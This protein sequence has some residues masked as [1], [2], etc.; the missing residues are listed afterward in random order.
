MSLEIN[1]HEF[2]ET[3]FGHVNIILD[4]G[5]TH[6][7]FIKTYD[8]D[9]KIINTEFNDNSY[10]FVFDNLFTHKDT[11]ET[12]YRNSIEHILSL[13]AEGQNGLIL[14]YS[15]SKHIDL[16]NDLLHKAFQYFSDLINTSDLECSVSG[17]V[18]LEASD[19]IDYQS[20]NWNT[21]FG[22][23]EHEEYHK[24]SMFIFKLTNPETELVTYL[25]IINLIPDS[26]D[27][28][29]DTLFTTNGYSSAENESEHMTNYKMLALV[30][31]YLE[32][33]VNKSIFITISPEL[34]R[35]QETLTGL[36]T[37]SSF[38]IPITSELV[39]KNDQMTERLESEVDRL[40]ENSSKFDILCE[41]LVNEDERNK[42]IINSLERQIETDN[43]IKAFEEK[44]MRKIN[45][46]EQFYKQTIRK[47]N[48]EYQNN[49]E[50]FFKQLK[51]SENTIASLEQENRVVKDENKK[52]KERSDFDSNGLK[53]NFCEKL[54]NDL[55]Q[56]NRK[57]KKELLVKG[58]IIGLNIGY[59]IEE[60][61]KEI[62]QLSKKLR[63]LKNATQI[64]Q[65]DRV[66]QSMLTITS[67]EM[68]EYVDKLSSE[69]LEKK[70]L[71][72]MELEN[73]ILELK[74]S[75]KKRMREEARRNSASMPEC[76][77]KSISS[78]NSNCLQKSTSTIGQF[79]EGEL[80]NKLNELR[81][82][83]IESEKKSMDLE[84]DFINLKL[85]INK[86]K[87]KLITL[88]ELT[89][90]FDNNKLNLSEIN[91][92]LL[93]HKTDHKLKLS[94]LSE[95]IDRLKESVP[96]IRLENLD[97]LKMNNPTKSNII[98]KYNLM[99]SCYSSLVQ[100]ILKSSYRNSQIFLKAIDVMIKRVIA[101]VDK[102]TLDTV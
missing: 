13:S 89:M 24:Y 15:N 79:E 8:T 1:Q 39:F 17:I 68:F 32:A 54:M 5:I 35:Y 28:N 82:N 45:E 94:S 63:D 69:E 65:E 25:Y 77:L 101:V 71:R 67:C 29:E 76:V 49:I 93:L 70:D 9:T 97:T 36:L 6:K 16:T 57:L 58:N 31:K 18:D 38:I 34:H 102:D 52:L 7:S 19:S 73:Q 4:S 21:K 75:V 50:Q 99:L 78:Y 59:F 12:I 85:Q 100:D 30:G 22:D 74:T 56:E 72:I 48:Q 60:Y 66:I 40:I 47:N 90:S 42:N 95:L 37:A 23:V 46:I 51:E 20:I 98:D 91:E 62:F 26:V 2:S 3:N 27:E 92:K 84:K 14:A 55:Y 61:Q 64:N 86:N 87:D 10:E 80:K 53:L 96:N 43:V 83:T 88:N 33:S 41:G 11:F 44:A 81:C